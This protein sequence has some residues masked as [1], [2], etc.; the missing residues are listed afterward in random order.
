MRVH[1]DLENMKTRV[2]EEGKEGGRANPGIGMCLEV[3]GLPEARREVGE[4]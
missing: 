3:P 2:G 4:L 1:R